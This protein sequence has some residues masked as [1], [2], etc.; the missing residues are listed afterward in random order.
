MEPIAV[1]VK[2]SSIHIEGFPGA[3]KIAKIDG[4]KA[5]RLSGLALHRVPICEGRSAVA[6]CRE[7]MNMT[8]VRVECCSIPLDGYGA[9]PHQDIS[10]PLGVGGTDLHRW[11]VPTR[12][13]QRTLLGADSGATRIDLSGVRM[14]PVRRIGEGP[15]SY[16]GAPR[17][18]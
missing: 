6:S 15:L 11:L 1:M 8:R 5:A 12:T 7:G 14:R 17:A 18:S 4:P 3:I 9:G 10:N 2:G 13:F 16:C